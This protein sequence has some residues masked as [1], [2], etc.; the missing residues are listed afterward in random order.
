MAKSKSWNAKLGRQGTI[1]IQKKKTGSISSEN[2]VR[3]EKA[4]KQSL[5]E[6]GN[7]SSGKWNGSVS[8]LMEG[9]QV[10]AWGTLQAW[11]NEELSAT[12]RRGMGL[13]EERE[14]EIQLKGK[15]KHASNCY[16]NSIPN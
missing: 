1:R 6:W 11:H 10:K 9:G 12:S 7:D 13:K 2:N 15:K 3:E 14:E 16:L 8:G 4:A 5:R